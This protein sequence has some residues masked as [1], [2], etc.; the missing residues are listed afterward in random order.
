MARKSFNQSGQPIIINDS[1]PTSVS[2]VAEQSADA[3]SDYGIADEVRFDAGIEH[4]TE[5][6]SV[7]EDGSDFEPVGEPARTYTEPTTATTATRKPRKPRGPNKN[8]A[9][10]N[11][12]FATA[13]LEKVLYNM[14]AMG[15]ALL[16]EP[17]LE[18]SEDEAKLLATAVGNVAVAYN[19]SAIMSPKTQASIDLA[20]ALVTVYGRRTM[21][22]LSRPKKVRGPQVVRQ[23]PQSL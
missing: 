4:N 18:I 23:T 20:I 14:H 6:G 19:I 15:A 5:D 21:S 16:L 10:V 3:G 17:E 12:T 22:I 8:K 9:S 1:S 11:L 2:G 13:N 7:G